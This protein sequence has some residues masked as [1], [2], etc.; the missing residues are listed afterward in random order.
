MSE[1]V[2]LPLPVGWYCV[3]DEAELAA[4]EVRRVRYFGEE[5]VLWRGADGAP[6][7]FDAYCPHLGAHL[8]VGGR[9]E[10]EGLRCPFHAWKFDGG[11]RCV[12][13]PYA[14]RIPPKAAVRA[15]PITRRSGLVFAW[16]DPSGG[17]PRFE[18]PA[19]P[20]WGSADWTAP[21]VRSF[22]VRTH[23]QEMAEN[24]VDAVHFRFVHGTPAIPEMKAESRG[25]EFHAA[26]GLTFTTPQG[27]I[28]G[29]VEIRMFGPGFGLTR[30]SGVVETLLVITGIPL[31]RE[32]HR[33]TIRFSVKKS[34]AGEEAT[35]GV[36]RAFVAEIAR[37]YTQDI[38][39]WE[40][41]RYWERPLLCDGD[42]PILEMRR[43]F[44]QFYPA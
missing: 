37:Q 1:R 23:P 28:R 33:T 41:K 21:E 14:K 18:L 15:W 6:H 25:L 10:G 39:I 4:G 34:A 19:L 8:G 32:L 7:L 16:Y 11:G 43:Y 44:A 40:N 12:D 38:P 5:L 29:S 2:P 35:R 27:E 17:A 26:Q 42:G 20:E 31:E 3:A 9:V 24:I 30:F 36:A 22:E 13:I